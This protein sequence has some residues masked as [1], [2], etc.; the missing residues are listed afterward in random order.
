MVKL[1]RAYE[2]WSRDD[3]FR[4]L[5][6]RLWPRGVSKEKA[7]LDLWL[8]EIAPSNALRKWFAHDPDKW[9]EFRKKYLKELQNSRGLVDQ[10]KAIEKKHKTLTLVYGARDT[11]QN[12]A[13]ILK[14]LIT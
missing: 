7:H 6:D 13:V 5:V 12:E 8:K 10:L 9:E 11:Q 2:P 1:K 14:D 4:V 3:G